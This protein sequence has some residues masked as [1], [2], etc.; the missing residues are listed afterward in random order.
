MKGATAVL[1]V[2]TISAPNK[3]KTIIIGASHHFLRTLRK[4]HNSFKI[5]IFGI[6]ASSEFT[7]SPDF[8]SLIRNSARKSCGAKM[9]AS[10]RR[11]A[12]LLRPDLIRAQNFG[13]N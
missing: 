3:T 4:F 9:F 10:L 13:R 5:D 1:S 7:I 12:Y 2:I 8:S 6:P 11:R